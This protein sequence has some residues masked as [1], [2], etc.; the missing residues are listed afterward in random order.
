M[1]NARIFKFG[2]VAIIASA[3]TTLQ[4]G[5]NKKPDREK[6]KKERHHKWDSE[7]M[8]ERL[9]AAFDKRKKRRDD[10]KKGGHKV[11]DHKK[12][13]GHRERR[14]FGKLVY[15]DAKVKELRNAFKEASKKHW[16]SFDK[17]AWKDASDEERKALREKLAASKTEWMQQ[18]KAHRKEVHARI[19]EIREEFKNNRDKVID[20]NEPGE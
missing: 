9:K 11:L 2:L 19:K 14:V 6:P 17:S 20:G 12:G 4:A 8:K 5:P 13:K 18:V 10:A 7:K 15:D 1:F 3:L 16:A